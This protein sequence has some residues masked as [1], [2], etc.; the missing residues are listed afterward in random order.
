VSQVSGSLSQVIF[1]DIIGTNMEN[2]F[3]QSPVVSGLK[4]QNSHPLRILKPTL[5]PPHQNTERF[6]LKFMT[7]KVEI[8]KN[9]SLK[10]QKNAQEV[11]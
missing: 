6:P 3:M 11:K 7:F 8:F 4:N 10:N 9:I 1:E 5:S 2:L